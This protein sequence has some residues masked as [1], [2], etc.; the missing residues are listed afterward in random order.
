MNSKLKQKQELEVFVLGYLG[1]LELVT[2]PSILEKKLFS[3]LFEIK[4]P[5]KHISKNNPTMD[6]VPINPNSSPS[7]EKIKSVFFSGRKS[8]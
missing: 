6:N 8:R 3:I 1:L 4:Y 2:D 5:V 7:I